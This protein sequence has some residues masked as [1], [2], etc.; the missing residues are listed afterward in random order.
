MDYL[1]SLLNRAVGDEELARLLFVGAIGLSVVLAVV[2]L[3]LL[4]LGLQDPVQRRL[5]LI[6]R[7]H[8]GGTMGR[9]RQATCN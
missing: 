2:T 3:A 7:G 9:T 5:S 8:A 1:L 4:V 6:K